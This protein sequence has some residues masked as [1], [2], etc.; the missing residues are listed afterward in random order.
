MDRETEAVAFRADPDS[1][2]R[3]LEEPVLLDEWQAVPGVL[4]AVKRAVDEDARPGRYLLAGSARD[5]LD[6]RMW[7]GTGRLVSVPMYGLTERERRGDLS[8]APFL[9]RLLSGGVETLREPQDP[10]DLRMYVAQALIGGFPEPMLYLSEQPRRRWLDSYID[11]LLT[12]DVEQL[13]GSR[14]P[15]RLRRYFEAV[16][17]NTAGV[18]QDKALHDAAAITARTGSA[19]EQVLRNLYVVDALPAWTTNRLKRLTRSPKRYVVDPALAGSALSLDENGVLRE[20]A[21]LGRMIETLVAAQL[22]GELPFASHRA[23][24]HHLRQ[25]DGRHEV[26]VVA[27]FGGGRVVAIEVKAHSAPTAGM[28]KHLRWLREEL[29]DRFV[30]GVVLHT[31]PRVYEL[32]DRIAAAP[33]ATLWS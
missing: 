15:E 9:D 11:R 19:Y 21:I 32:D 26:D 23:R 25:Y 16:A 2:L 28:A 8:S 24:L 29:G 3:G 10:P 14:D 22:R 13:A 4:G 27:E 31:G 18:V 20:G 1:A 7:P 12:R 33:I 17:S 30:A 6:V 5:P